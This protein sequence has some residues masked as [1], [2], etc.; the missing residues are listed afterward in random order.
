MTNINWTKEV[1][2]TLL[3][4][5]DILTAKGI[6]PTLRGM[7]YRLLT[8]NLFRNLKDPY[9]GLSAFTGRL[10]K[11]SVLEPHSNLPKLPIDCFADDTRRVVRNW[12]NYQKPQTFIGDIMEDATSFPENYRK[13]IP[14]WYEQPHYVEIWVE[15]RALIRTLQV[16]LGDRQVRIVPLSGYSSIPFMYDN[17]T[18]LADN[19][20][21]GKTVHILYLGDLDPSGEDIEKNVR[22]NLA[23][24]GIEEDVDFQKIG[25]TDKQRLDYNLPIS[26]DEKVK[27]KLKND[28][29]S[30]S[31]TRRRGGGE[32]YQV[33]VDALETLRPD[34]FKESITEPIDEWFKQYI[35]DD[36]M[37]RE[38]H[39][40]E[41]L[42]KLRKAE[43]K[44]LHKDIIRKK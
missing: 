26:I 10:R 40:E 36:V 39:T 42:K 17:M 21:I 4:Q 32:P 8:F 18:R 27:Q 34:E 43:V 23:D 6:I 5:L 1:L 9:D 7:Y 38:I 15:K 16:V 2:P 31:F 20:T 13:A 44:K 28:R 30:I 29:R 3:E 14:R 24:Y 41:Y 37:N 22:S 25:V 19:V 35:Y 33:E 12:T 11:R